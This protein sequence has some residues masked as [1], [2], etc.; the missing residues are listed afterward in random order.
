[1]EKHA[2]KLTHYL[3]FCFQSGRRATKAFLREYFK[4]QIY[5]SC[6]SDRE[7]YQV[8]VRGATTRDDESSPRD[9]EYPRSLSVVSDVSTC[10]NKLPPL[11]ESFS[12]SKQD[13]VLEQKKKQSRY[14]SAGSCGSESS[15]TSAGKVSVDVPRSPITKRKSPV[16]KT[17]VGDM[18][19]LLWIPR[20]EMF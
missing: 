16:R 8:S 10:S 1:M 7:P 13:K 18:T 17:R 20:E 4:R 9:L 2:W 14:S 15:T 12:Y 3:T 5:S 11:N 19:T 6:S